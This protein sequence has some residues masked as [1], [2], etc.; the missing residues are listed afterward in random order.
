MVLMGIVCLFFVPFIYH[1][2][3]KFAQVQSSTRMIK[4]DITS[5]N[6]DKAAL[7]LLVAAAVAMFEVSSRARDFLIH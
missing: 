6:V 1:K 5:V 4:K 7:G 2:L 3:Y